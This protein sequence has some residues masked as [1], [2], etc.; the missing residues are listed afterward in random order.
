M[1]RFNK[2]YE[3]LVKDYMEWDV[4]KH[5]CEFEYEMGYIS[6]AEYLDDIREC[7]YIQRV[8]M[9]TIEEEMN[10]SNTNEK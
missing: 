2:T 4:E 1:N 8:I 3:E 7:D 5:R 6:E 9:D 10:E